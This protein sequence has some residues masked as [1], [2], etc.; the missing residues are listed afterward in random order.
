MEILEDENIELIGSEFAKDI[1]VGEGDQPGRGE[2]IEARITAE[3][4]D[5]TTRRRWRHQFFGWCFAFISI[6]GAIRIR[7]HC[8]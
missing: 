2:I 6:V 7:F 1:N 4:G 3:V 5:R 8:V